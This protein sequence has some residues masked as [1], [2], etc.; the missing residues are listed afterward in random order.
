MT[1]IASELPQHT[2]ASPSTPAQTPAQAPAPTAAA[3]ARVSLPP[4]GSLRRAPHVHAS[5]TPGAHRP[6]RRADREVR[7]PQ[8]I[9]DILDSCEVVRIA[10]QDAEGLTIVPMNFGY[11]FTLERFPQPEND[12]PVSLSADGTPLPPDFGEL[13]I[14]LHS[15]HEGRKIDAIRAAGNALQVAFE[16]DCDHQVHE[17]RT[18]CNWSASFRSIVGTGTASVVTD[19]D[20]KIV[21]MQALMSKQAGMDHV[22]FTAR[23]MASVTVW[24]ITSTNFTGKI[25][26]V[27]RQ[28]GSK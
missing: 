28:H 2:P 13:R 7:S 25:H 5:T 4:S 26:T 15:A 16:L 1:D 11:Q 22:P 18:P 9:K 10:Y 21:A 14:F 8:Q 12:L 27:P 20:E 6:M 19:L 3:V 23:Q 17:G 24:Q